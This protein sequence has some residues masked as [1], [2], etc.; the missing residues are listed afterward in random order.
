VLNWSR[1][2]DTLACLRS[3]AAAVPPPDGH[4][5]LVVDNGST[6]D[7]IAAIR[8]ALPTV[9]VL[10]LPH[11]VG[12]AAG[13][14]AGLRVALEW[15]PRWTLLVNNDTTV[16]PDLPGVLLAA[17]A[18]AD[19]GLVAPTIVHMDAPDRIW[20]SAGR[21]RGLTLAA[22]DTSSH[23]PSP[24]PYDVDWAAACVLAVRRE[25]WEQVGLLDERYLVY[26]EDH[27]LCLRARRAGWRVRHAP[28]AVARHKV[29]ASSG[30]GSPRQLYLLARSSVPFY[31][32]HTRGAHR[33][34]IVAYRLGSL[35]KKLLATAS[36]GRAAA[37]WAYLRGLADGLRDVRRQALAPDRPPAF[38]AAI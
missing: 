13:V 18:A 35:V 34:F 30:E 26:Y 31:L 29:A 11:N 21:R 16:A 1:R 24:E 20:S 7:S 19:V 2:D 3:L 28:R 9:D 17:G 33:W 27:D 10:A 15:R 8:A 38:T 23:P 25:V 14:N 36:A 32:R 4:R 37:G 12:Y 6:D 22:I 5:I